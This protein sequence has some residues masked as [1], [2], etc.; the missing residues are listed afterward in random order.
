MTLRGQQS[1]DQVFRAL[2]DPTRRAM[3]RKLS[4]GDAC[5]SELA[6]DSDMTQS[7]VSQHLKILRDAGLVKERLEAHD[8]AAPDGRGG[9][10]RR[11]TL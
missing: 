1:E 10:R 6:A 11:R 8:R 7:A 9:P 3:I 2:A 5:V 4:A